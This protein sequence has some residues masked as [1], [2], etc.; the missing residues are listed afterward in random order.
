MEIKFEEL[1]PIGSIVYLNGSPKKVMITGT[2]GGIVENGKNIVGDYIGCLWPEGIIDTTKN[3]LFSREDIANTE[4]I[5]VKE[6]EELQNEEFTPKE[7]LLPLGSIVSVKGSKRKLMITG[8]YITPKNENKMHDYLGCIWPEGILDTS[9]SIVFN[10]DRISI[11]HAKGYT[12]EE[13]Q[14]FKEKLKTIHEKILNSKE[15]V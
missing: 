4:I 8:F 7:D 6:E 11:L 13:E 2:I 10:N 1:L 14:K 5:G 3:L 12:N 15:V 9:K